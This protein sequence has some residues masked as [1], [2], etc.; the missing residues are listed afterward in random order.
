[1]PSIVTVHLP[2]RY[3]VH[4]FDTASNDAGATKALE[5]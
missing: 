1:M 2:F 3:H 4:E 5:S